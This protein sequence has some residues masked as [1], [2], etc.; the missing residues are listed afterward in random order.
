M[1]HT[2]QSQTRVW[3]ELLLEAEWRPHVHESGHQ[4]QSPYYARHE[5]GTPRRP[6]EQ[7]SGLRVPAIALSKV[8]QA[9][10][11]RL[12]KYH[13]TE[14]LRCQSLRDSQADSLRCIH[15]GLRK[16]PRAALLDLL[17]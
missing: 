10:Y 1:Q 16:R 12:M 13:A 8:V 2:L 5:S 7:N 15:Y 6:L 14:V 9:Q 4:E 17:L 3:A 11:D